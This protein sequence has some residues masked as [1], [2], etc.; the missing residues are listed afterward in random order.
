MAVMRIKKKER[1]LFLIDS[2]GLLKFV[3]LPLIDRRP[4]LKTAN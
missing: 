4:P 1:K 3:S 2:D